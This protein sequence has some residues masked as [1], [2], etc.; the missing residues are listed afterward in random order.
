MGCRT[1]AP[2]G[3]VVEGVV[4]A[5]AS[6]TAWFEELFGFREGGSYRENR[7]H[8]RMEGDVLCVDGAPKHKQHFVGRWST[9]SLAELR[10]ELGN[11]GTGGLRFKHLPTPTGAEPLI[12][13]MAQGDDEG[14]V[15]AAV[16]RVVDAIEQTGTRAAE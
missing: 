11:G 15:V 10:E 9:P 4:P 7:A 5:G 14:E 8:F 2:A 1:S 3:V 13:V 12:R 6:S 16:D